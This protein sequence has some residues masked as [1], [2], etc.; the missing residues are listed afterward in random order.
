MKRT[1]DIETIRLGK[2]VVGI[3]EGPASISALGHLDGVLF[4]ERDKPLANI[5][6]RAG[7]GVDVYVLDSGI[8]HEHKDF[9]GR[10]FKGMNFVTGESDEDLYGHGTHVSGTVAGKRFG[11]AKS[12]RLFGVKILNRKGEGTVSLAVRAIN[13]VIQQKITTGRKSII[14][15]SLVGEFSQALNVAVDQASIRN[16]I[17]VIVAAGNQHEDACLTS[18]ASSQNVI[19]VGNVDQTNHLSR[20]SN[21]GACVS[22]FA[23]GAKIVSASNL[24]PVGSK[25]LS[26]TR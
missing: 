4:A 21:T 20:S 9:E 16:G 11:V 2:V 6:S 1:R 10:A 26:G 14:N 8:N 22:I 24:D 13:Y 18:P 15:L 5:V 7:L 17:P 3:L 19:A 12:A 25:V 23:P